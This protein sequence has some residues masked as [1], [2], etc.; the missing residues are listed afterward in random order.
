MRDDEEE[1]QKALLSPG[2]TASAFTYQASDLTMMGLTT[3]SHYSTVMNEER[4]EKWD[5]EASNQRKISDT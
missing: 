3:T 1:G 4:N 2:S 5:D